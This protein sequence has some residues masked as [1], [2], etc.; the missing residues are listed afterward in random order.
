MQNKY[1]YGK[2]SHKLLKIQNK[3]LDGIFGK[4]YDKY[5]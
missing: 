1:S 2:P 5:I 4:T 3:E